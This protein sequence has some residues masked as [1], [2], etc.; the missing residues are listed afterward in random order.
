M[1]RKSKKKER[2]VAGA[3][4]LGM[5]VAAMMLCAAAA[6]QSGTVAAGGAATGSG[7]GG[8]YTMGYS[9]GQVV[10]SAAA[11]EGIRLGEGLQQGFTI[12]V[13]RIGGVEGTPQVEIFPNPTAGQ[14]VL[15]RGEGHA[16]TSVELY[17]ADG[18][19]IES[20][21]WQGAELRLD[22]SALPAGQYMLHI[23]AAAYKVIK[24]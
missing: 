3:R 20:R 9:L 15:R 14:L 12:E 17:S 5:A 21:P 4:R 8:G 24:R 13:E 1:N 2:L 18:R 7:S 16:E 6:A 11:A 19:R 10:A 22:L 23:E